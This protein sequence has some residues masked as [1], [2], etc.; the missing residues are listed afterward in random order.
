LSDL[1]AGRRFYTIIP[2]TWMAKLLETVMKSDESKLFSR[3]SALGLLGGAAGLLVNGS[4]GET[5][6]AASSAC[7]V[8]PEAEIGPFFVD[9]GSA[10]FNRSNVRSNVD[11]TATQRGVP[12]TLT[13][14]VYD[15]HA[16][17]APM[18]GVQVDLWHCNASGVYSAEP[19][20]GT[21]SQTW[22]RGYQVTGSNGTVT[23]TTIFPGWYRGRTTHIH[24][25]VRSKYSS[26]SSPD[27]GTN[28][29]QLFFPQDV[30]NAISTSVKP[31]SAR[32]INLRTNASD[33]VYRSETKGKTELV[34]SGSVGSGY[35]AIVSIGLP[36]T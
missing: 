31:Y 34:L 4:G 24:L 23:F 30:I 17:C 29:T 33:Y 10:R 11:G 35:A 36:I 32:G 27:D 21:A 12:L 1:P 2:A 8:T 20:E 9:D 14:Q 13:L 6:E 28:T 18:S 22:L 26:A 25:R 16:A 7:A 15:T 19:S 3:A 5:A